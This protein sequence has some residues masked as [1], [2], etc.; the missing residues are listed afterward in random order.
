MYVA[1]WFYEVKQNS[2]MPYANNLK[3]LPTV[4]LNVVKFKSPMFIAPKQ[5]VRVPPVYDV[6][7]RSTGGSSTRAWSGG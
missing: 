4:T 6:L 7:G 2:S 3:K 5:L 1:S